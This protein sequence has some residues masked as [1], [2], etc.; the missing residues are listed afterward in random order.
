MGNLFVISKKSF[1]DQY[2]IDVQLFDRF[3]ASHH[4]LKDDALPHQ[5][6]LKMY[7]RWC[8]LQIYHRDAL[9]RLDGTACADTT[10]DYRTTQA[11]I[12]STRLQQTVAR[13]PSLAENGAADP[14][15]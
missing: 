3:V 13:Q 12:E 11:L 4:K 5:I 14:L 9:A 8:Q 10:L 2:G 1:C 6:I 7:I 15:L